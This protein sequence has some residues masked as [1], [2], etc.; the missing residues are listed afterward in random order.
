[1]NNTI[2]IKN[3][4]CGK[5]PWYHKP[6]WRD[7][8]TMFLL[9]RT[10][11]FS[12]GVIHGYNLKF[13]KINGDSPFFHSLWPIPLASWQLHQRHDGP[14][15]RSTS[16]T[17]RSGNHHESRGTGPKPSIKITNKGRAFQFLGRV[18]ALEVIGY[19]SCWNN[20]SVCAS[21]PDPQWARSGVQIFLRLKLRSLYYI[22][23][24]KQQF[25]HLER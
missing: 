7:I 2:E 14:S 17:T 20:H 10:S 8:K 5:P 24:L 19:K 12:K 6:Q 11:W 23:C 25:I 3:K 9:H 18:T 15:L 21:L 13:H 16:E 22:N 4:N 1:M